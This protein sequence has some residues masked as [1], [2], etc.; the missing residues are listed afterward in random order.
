MKKREIL[1]LSS[2]TFSMGVIVGFFISPVKEGIYNF[3][4]NGQSLTKIQNAYK[5]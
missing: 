2:L 4:G 3:A 5:P 1:L